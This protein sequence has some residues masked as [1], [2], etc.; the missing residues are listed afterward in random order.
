MFLHTAHSLQS[1][2]Y[3]F[4]LLYIH[5]LICSFLHSCS[6]SIVITIG[7]SKSSTIIRHCLF[8]PDS[9]CR[10]VIWFLY[11]TTKSPCITCKCLSLTDNSSI[12][13]QELNKENPKDKLLVLIGKFAQKNRQPSRTAYMP[14][15]CNTTDD[16]ISS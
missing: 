10:H 1:M 14:I 11:H 6:N 4:L 13:M 16:F 5:P 2:I 7:K 3:Q 8:P 9:I 12:S 15:E